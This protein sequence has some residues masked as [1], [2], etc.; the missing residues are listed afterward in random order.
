[1][2]VSLSDRWAVFISKFGGSP[3]DGLYVFST[4]IVTNKSQSTKTVSYYDE[5]Q[6]V[7]TSELV[8]YFI[9]YTFEHD[10]I[11]YTNTLK[12]S[13]CNYKYDDYYG[14][15]K[16]GDEI[17]I[18]FLENNAKKALFNYADFKVS[19]E[20]VVSNKV[21]RSVNEQ[22]MLKNYGHNYEAISCDLG[23]ILF[24]FRTPGDDFDIHI[25]E[26]QFEFEG[27]NY[28]IEYQVGRDC[29]DSYDVGERISLSFFKSAP[30]RSVSLESE[31]QGISQYDLTGVD[32]SE[33]SSGT[34]IN[35]V[36]RNITQKVITDNFGKLEYEPKLDD[37]GSIHRE[38]QFRGGF[39]LYIVECQFEYN[40]TSYKIQ[41]QLSGA[42][43]NQIE[44]GD[45][46]PISFFESEP[47]SASIISEYSDINQFDLS[48]IEFESNLKTF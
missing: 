41:V 20:G 12:S 15:L 43:Y 46:L 5:E 35:K 3:I 39:E 18:K 11:K 23:S 17:P 47:E 27:I 34:V 2:T 4:G 6:V 40:L 44:L 22:T 9:E 19:K 16:V 14:I 7:R 13:D 28:D 37:F 25:M 30:Q 45:E 10:S 26:Y 33:E 48:G 29:F 8:T 38:F 31:R 32:F 36:I 42:H 1:M 21:V 24:R